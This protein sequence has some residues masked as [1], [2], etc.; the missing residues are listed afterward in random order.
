MDIEIEEKEIDLDKIIEKNKGH[1]ARENA[2]DKNKENT[3]R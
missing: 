1:K 2:R 3:K